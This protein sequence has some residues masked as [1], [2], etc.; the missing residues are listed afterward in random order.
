VI[1]GDEVCAGCTELMRVLISELDVLNEQGVSELVYQEFLEFS[2][3]RMHNSVKC[4]E[5][6]MLVIL[7]VV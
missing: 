1:S 6:I 4:W 5:W 2:C 3:D 7:H